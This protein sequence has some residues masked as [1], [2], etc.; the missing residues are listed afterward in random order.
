M[1]SFKDGDR[2]FAKMRGYP[3]WPARVDSKCEVLGKTRYNVFFYGTYQVWVNR[4]I[5]GVILLNFVQICDR[6]S[7]VGTIFLH[8]R[9]VVVKLVVFSKIH[10]KPEQNI[11]ICWGT[12]QTHYLF[13]FYDNNCIHVFCLTNC[14]I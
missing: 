10:A 6:N 11:G 9:S 5:S 8:L 12:R 14:F 1:K 7:S 4:A 2:V 13:L 3:C